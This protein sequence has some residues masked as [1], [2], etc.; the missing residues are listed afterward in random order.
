MPPRVEGRP[1]LDVGLGGDCTNTSLGQLND[2]FSLYNTIPY[3][4][5]NIDDYKFVQTPT[6]PTPISTPGLS[7]RR[8]SKFNPHLAHLAGFNYRKESCGSCHKNLHK[9]GRESLHKD[10]RY[11]CKNCRML[12]RYE[13]AIGRSCNS[14]ADDMTGSTSSCLDKKAF[15]YTPSHIH[16]A[17][18]SANAYKKKME[19]QNFKNSHFP[20]G[21]LHDT[22]S[23][24]NLARSEYTSDANLTNSQDIFSP[25]P[26]R[27]ISDI[28]THSLDHH[29]EFQMPYTSSV[30]AI[31]SR[32]MSQNAGYSIRDLQHSFSSEHDY[33]SQSE[34]R[35]Q[36]SLD[37][38]STSL[39][40]HRD[41]SG[42]IDSRDSMLGPYSVDNRSNSYLHETDILAP[43]KLL[44]K[45]FQCGSNSSS[46]DHS[47]YPHSL[48]C[49]TKSPRL[50]ENPCE[51]IDQVHANYHRA[52]PH[53]SFS[54]EGTSVGENTRSSSMNSSMTSLHL[55][56]S[57]SRP[58]SSRC[59]GQSNAPGRGG[60]PSTS[61][62]SGQQRS[63]HYLHLHQQQQQY[64]SRPPWYSSTSINTTTEEEEDQESEDDD[65][66]AI[67]VAERRSKES[68]YDAG[69]RTLNKS[70]ESLPHSF[71]SSQI[72]FELN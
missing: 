2:P 29:N 26:R 46:F 17:I 56:P 66:D 15:Y 54:Y 22:K 55:S 8:F 6:T 33:N 3:D 72:N 48:N 4:Y 47:S 44:S 70:R 1:D 64:S 53:S 38:P 36:T 51:N 61:S 45:Y 65:D 21:T 37:Y 58:S 9:Q 25:N 27:K 57:H 43:N 5:A 12:H 42:T 49:M 71:S 23:E 30:S 62:A 14:L 67:T 34:L 18:L 10:L 13:D 28:C 31:Y 52:T 32:N 40:I 60:Q 16:L 41:S 35:S 11:F 19:M 24:S 68:V 39:Q 50:L 20:I 69:A 59:P 7:P 63:S